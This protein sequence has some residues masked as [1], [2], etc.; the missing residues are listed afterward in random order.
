M[1]RTL[2]T[3]RPQLEKP[4]SGYRLT[5]LR[6]ILQPPH[7]DSIHNATEPTSSPPSHSDQKLH[8]RVTY[9]AL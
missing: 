4:H 3:H 9:F 7:H 2:Q 6:L 1:D 8:R 5:A